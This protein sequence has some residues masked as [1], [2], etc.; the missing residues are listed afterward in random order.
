MVDEF[1]VRL[2]QGRLCQPWAL[3]RNPVG[4]LGTVLICALS[5]FVH[6]ASA[7]QTNKPNVVFILI[8]DMGYADTSCY[9]TSGT[10]VVTTTNIDRLA[11]QGIRFTQYHAASPICS[12][13]RTGLLTGSYPGRWRVTSYLDNKSVNRSRN[14]ADFADPLAPNIGRAFKAA[15]YKT[16]HFG[17]W[18]LDSGRN[19]DDSPLPQAYGFDESVVS[20]EGLGNR[21]LFNGDAL[22]TLSAQ[23]KQGVLEWMPKA[24]AASNQVND[25]VA[26]LAAHTNDPCYVNL[27]FNDVHTAWLPAAGTWSKY[28]TVTSDVNEQKF[29]AVLENLDLQIGRF[30]TALDNLKLTTNTIV[31]YASDNGAPGDGT[32]AFALARNGGLRGRKGSLYEGG[33][34]LPFIVRWPNHI[35]QGAI[36]TNTVLSGVDFLPTVCSLAQISLPANNIPDGEDMSAAILGQ[37][38]TRTKPIYWWFIN[39]AGP[40]VG[41]YHH[42]PPLALRIGNWKVLTDYTKSVIEL[43]DLNTD[44]FETTNVVGSQSTLANSMA[45]QLITWWQTMPK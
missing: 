6:V 41:N 36:N 44:P 25:A 5:L 2:S 14:M 8:D 30:L 15:G 39:D 10:P 19:V 33:T 45:D 32:T 4:I 9:R 35:P 28:S 40:G 13:S 18:H 38:Q 20:F 23:A 1:L 27:W 16:G 31:I 12:P 34:R 43:Y 17:K 21:V 7:A 29:Y 42:A 37:S 24:E 3:G 11:S 26:F 22:S